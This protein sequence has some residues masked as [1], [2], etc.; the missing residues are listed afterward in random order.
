MLESAL[1]LG[2]RRMLEGALAVAAATVLP[3]CPATAYDTIMPTIP[4]SKSSL[5]YDLTPMPPAAVDASAAKLTQ[6]ERAVSL[7]A[8]TEPPFVGKT[9][10]GFGHDNKEIG[11]YVG[12]ISGLPLFSSAAKFDSGTGWPS[13]FAPIAQDHVLERL[14]PSDL[15]RG[16]KRP[17]VEVLDPVSGAHLGHV[18][19]D[20]PAPTGLR[21]CMNAASMRFVPG[22]PT[23]R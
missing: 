14:D 6:L 13:F 18:F 4:S 19:A 17:R 2:R 16:S 21:F 10:N 7:S 5:G 20:G 22:P 3:A 11:Q 1:V 23:A 15:A 12:A 8:F 9:T